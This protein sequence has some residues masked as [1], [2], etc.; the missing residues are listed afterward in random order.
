MFLW[1][2]HA[3]SAGAIRNQLLHFDIT[4][5]VFKFNINEDSFS[6][7]MNDKAF[8]S[9]WKRYLNACCINNSC[10]NTYTL[11]YRVSAEIVKVCANR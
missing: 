9:Q 8:R 7:P 3:D 11:Q 6:F 4:Q 5:V 10:L 2:K 1:V